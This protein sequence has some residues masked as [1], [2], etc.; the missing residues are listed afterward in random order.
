MGIRSPKPVSRVRSVAATAL[1][2]LTGLA[3]AIEADA[4]LKDRIYAPG[5]SFRAGQWT[6]LIEDATTTAVPYLWC[7]DVLPVVL[8]LSLSESGCPTA[9]ATSQTIDGDLPRSA[10]AFNLAELLNS[11]TNAG[12]VDPTGLPGTFA[13]RPR[14]GFVRCW[15]E[16]L[17]NGSCIVLFD[18]DVLIDG[19]CE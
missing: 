8:G 7:Y 3:D 16:R 14:S 6:A 17:S 2:R 18:K 12:G 10:K 11:T 4:G 19:Q 15:Y 1:K 5:Y 13:P 9:A